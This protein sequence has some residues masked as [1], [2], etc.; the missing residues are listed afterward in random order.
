MLRTDHTIDKKALIN[1]PVDA[2]EILFPR[3]CV[4]TVL[5]S[6]SGPCMMLILNKENA[7]EEWRAMMGPADPEQ[8]KA[9]CPNSMRAR[10]AS[11]ILHNSLHGASTEE[12]AK[13]KIH[14]IFGDICSDVELSGDG[15]T[16]RTNIGTAVLL[17]S[18][19]LLQAP[20]TA[21]S[22]HIQLDFQLHIYI[23]F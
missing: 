5:F 3:M 16:D 20:K 23:C 13:E 4:K 6:T 15:E 8:A 7:V 2:V 11:D 1:I 14:F 10:F 22:P 12:R 21:D 19:M 17:V 18:A 9:T